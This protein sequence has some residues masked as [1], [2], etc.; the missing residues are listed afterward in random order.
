VADILVVDCGSDSG[1]DAVLALLDGLRVNAIGSNGESEQF[2]QSKMTEVPC[3][4]FCIT[5]SRHCESRE[6]VEE[7]LRTVDSQPVL[8]IDEH[9]VHDYGRLLLERGAQDY[10]D[11]EHLSHAEL[12]RRIDWAILRYG[13]RSSAPMLGRNHMADDD[14]HGWAK[15]HQV[16]GSVPPRE[17]QILEL[18]IAGFSAKQI[19]NKVGTSPKTVW[20]QLANLRLR[21]DVGSNH[22]LCLLVFRLSSEENARE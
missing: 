15:A 19:A 6:L 7:T 17:R 21:F 12:H 14:R 13:H 16:L 9:F 3:A 8:V 20:N 11:S 5:C 1:I 2:A 18:F 22:A 4:V 10:L